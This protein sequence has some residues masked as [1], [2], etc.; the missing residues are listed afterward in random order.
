MVIGHRV[1]IN[2]EMVMRDGV[3]PEGK[4]QLPAEDLYREF[5]WNYPKFFKMDKLCKWAFAGSELL[6]SGVDLTGLDKTKTGIVLATGH[7]CIDV[8]KRYLDTIAM[9]SPALFVYTLPN[10]MLGEICIRYGFK[11]GQLCMVSEA[12]DADELYFSV[13]QQFETGAL[14]ACLCGWV[15][16]TNELDVRMFW[17]TKDGNGAAF[18]AAAIQ[19]LHDEPQSV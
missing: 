5:K 17:V 19:E 13:T 10:I 14:E 15:D 12:F 11:G 16:V 7:G 1:V 3:L 18:T 8:D 6:L 9:P 4:H 2:N